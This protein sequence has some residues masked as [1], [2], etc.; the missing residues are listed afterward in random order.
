MNWLLL[1]FTPAPGQALIGLYDPW[2]VLLSVVVAIFTSTLALQMVELAARGT[3]W[4]RV[5]TITTGSLA[6]G[7]G[8]W[9]MHFIAMLAFNLCTT[10][11]YDPAITAISMLP[12]IA[13]SA[14]ALSLI[15]RP[16][17]SLANLLIGG[18]LVGGG[19]GAMHYV[20]MSALQMVP[21]LRYD[22]WFFSLSIVVAVV[23][24]VLA[25]WIRFR[26][27]TLQGK[28]WALLLASGTVMGCA[29]A[30]MHYTGM[31]AAR[32]WGDPSIQDP[33]TPSE[34]GLL[35]LAVT[36][37]TLLVALLVAA[38]N[39]LLRYR[40]MV[41]D[42]RASE[43]RIRA[44]MAT[45][46]DAIISIK[47]NGEMREVNH[48]AQAMFGWNAAEMVGKNVNMLMPEPHRS[49][50]DSYLAR[51]LDTREAR[52]IGAAREVMALRKDGST[53]P[54]RLAV[55]HAQLPEEDIFVGFVT[56][57]TERRELEQSLRDAKTRA[58]QAA[59]AR[60]AFLANMSHEIR[61]PMNSILGFA[62]VLLNTQLSGEQSHALNIVRNSARSLLRL[63]NE[64]LDSAKLDRGAIEI[65]H[66]P[67]DLRSLAEEI[68]A[69][70]T[71]I[72]DGKGLRLTLKYQSELPTRFL[73]DELRLRQVL[74]NLL[75]NAVKFTEK[76]WVELEIFDDESKVHFKITDTGIGIAPD[77]LERIFDPF[78]QADASLSRRYGGTG[79]GTT[80]SK[81]LVELMKGRVWVE[82][83]L[84]RGSQFHVVLPL[85]ATGRVT[86]EAASP[87]K[88]ISLPILD[89]LAVDDVPQNLELLRMMLG[90][91]GH[92]L[93]LVASGEEA[94]E[95]CAEEKYDIILLDIHMPGLS[96]LET[97]RQLRAREQ[98][99]NAAPVPIIAL[100]ASVLEA[101]RILAT[102]AGMT[103][104]VAKPIER[105][106]LLNEMAR[107]L[108]IGTATPTSSR[109]AAGRV[110]FDRE[111]ALMRW[112][113]DWLTLS[114]MLDQFFLENRGVA[115]QLTAL[116]Q[117]DAKDEAFHLAHR[118]KGVA[119]NLGLANLASAL[120]AVEAAVNGDQKGMSGLIKA[121]AAAMETA[122][123]TVEVEL[124]QHRPAK[125]AERK[126]FDAKAAAKEIGALQKAARRGALDDAALSELGK[127][128]PDD[129]IAPLKRAL[130]DF[131]FG[132]AE[133]LLEELAA[134]NGGAHE[135]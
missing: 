56:D 12:S 15:S 16:Q 123:R 19:I 110:V 77:R 129:Q 100:S 83:E 114:S 8:V 111:G 38:I 104:F 97:S 28:R 30:G 73:G 29:I 1:L 84:G 27:R 105:H 22:P 124:V 103:G 37:T 121:A 66:L 60:T 99:G 96:G 41:N 47:A 79:L 53:F 69:T 24:A 85:M 33:L 11:D 87:E 31:A 61:T 64:V 18:V 106:L 125:T 94:L 48:A 70:Q 13:A 50:H 9:A 74:T 135:L 116:L 81:Q 109:A 63:L 67:F 76:G 128:L 3:S 101:D 82:S 117:R 90:N 80:I 39:G 120:Q 58:E 21:V 86:A 14:V 98:R 107:A 40:A 45:A 17:I 26:L 6:L 130:E 115:T 118:V 89:I 78:T 122:W 25:L 133:S 57:I 54:I 20:G 7:S 59:A 93:T 127:M 108:G 42:L 43:S 51:F 36:F 2:L 49:G 44:M 72:A 34:S 62:E 10:V 131:D 4:L 126:E 75:G 23:L 119:G 134:A 91:M 52:I 68:V 46:V 35:A 88:T 112:D 71:T 5:A 55:G 65:L 32:F 92:N 95:R 102:E 113:D 132:L